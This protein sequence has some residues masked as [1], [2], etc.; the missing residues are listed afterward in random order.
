MGNEEVSLSVTDAV[1]IANVSVI[2]EAA[3]FALGQTYQDATDFARN[4]ELLAEAHL[5]KYLHGCVTIDPIEA[6]ANTILF[7]GM[8]DSSIASTTAQLAA[9]MQAGK[10]AMSTPPESG[11]AGQMAQMMALLAVSKSAF[12][13]I[14]KPVVAK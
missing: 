8:G 7:R 12:S 1:T 3:A 11:V 4:A 10:I 5:G 9:G 6:V 14:K 13:A 2:A